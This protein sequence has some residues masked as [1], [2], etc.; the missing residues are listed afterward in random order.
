MAGFGDV[1]EIGMRHQAFEVP[2]IIQTDHVAAARA[3]IEF[4]L[5]SEFTEQ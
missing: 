3:P 4:T 5:E 1:D 2:Y